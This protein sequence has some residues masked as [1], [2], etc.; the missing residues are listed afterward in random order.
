MDHFVVTQS[1]NRIVLEP[2]EPSRADEVRARL[3]ELEITEADVAKAIAWAR[4]RE[5]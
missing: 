4:E 5:K 1:G 3:K 2:L